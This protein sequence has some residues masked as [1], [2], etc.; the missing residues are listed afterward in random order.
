MQ[1]TR[2]SQDDFVEE[3]SFIPVNLRK[4]EQQDTSASWPVPARELRLRKSF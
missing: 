3:V 4:D 2:F 1:K